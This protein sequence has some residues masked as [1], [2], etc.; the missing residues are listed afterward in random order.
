MVRYIGAV[1]DRNGLRPSR[2]YLTTDNRVIM[3]SEVGV[4]PVAPEMVKEKGRLQPG[5]MFLIDFEQGRMIPD[6]ELKQ[7][8]SSR[9]PYAKWLD[10]H[11]ID[12]T[13]LVSQAPVPPDHKETLLARM[14][15]FGY[16]V[17][18][19]QFMLLPLVQEKRDPIG[20][21][22]NDSTLAC[23]SDQPRLIYDYFKQL[24]AQVT[25][26]AIDSIREDLIMS[27]ECYIGPEKNLLCPTEEHCCRLK[28]ANPI[29]LDEE[30]IAIREMKQVGWQATTLDITFQ[31]EEG[32][33]VSLLLCIA[34][35]ARQRQRLMR[36]PVLCCCQIETPVRNE[37]LSVLDGCGRCITTGGARK[38]TRVLSFRVWNVVSASS[39]FMFG[40]GAEGNLILSRLRSF[41]VRFRMTL[42]AINFDQGHIGPTGQCGEGTLKVG[43]KWEFP[44][45]NRTK[46]GRFSRHWVAR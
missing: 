2:Y 34:F 41:S 30:L 21:M 43:G 42:D 19:L 20:S 24:F 6:E 27:L 32:S 12:L 46:E 8:F 44:R 10:R 18:T 3:A 45:C 35:V 13:D 14:R 28:V 31:K 5:R 40:F 16:T 22:G 25:N 11:R 37:S 36:V 33:R 9:H 26:P 1:L 7:Q 17:E 4:L 38:R 29:L 23:L 15:T 39:L